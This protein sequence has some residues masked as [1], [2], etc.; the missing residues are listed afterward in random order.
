MVLHFVAW[1]DDNGRRHRCVI[2]VDILEI[3]TLDID[4]K[5]S[6]GS[7]AACVWTCKSLI[8]LLILLLQ[9]SI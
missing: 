9:H 3:R 4:R 6:Q 1:I 8:E 7:L 5:A 2:D